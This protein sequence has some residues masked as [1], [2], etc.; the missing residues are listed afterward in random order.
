M[1]EPADDEDLLTPTE[2]SDLLKHRV[3]IKTL[4][5]WRSDATC[6]GPPYRRYGNRI[7]YKRADVLA[8]DR[9]R[10]YGSTSDYRS[11]P[12]VAA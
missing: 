7:Y 5:N 3:S 12:R 2:V 10:T 8:W 4:A 1:A 11:T 6:P 9:S